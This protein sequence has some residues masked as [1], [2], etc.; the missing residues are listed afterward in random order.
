[1]KNILY[2]FALLLFSCKNNLEIEQAEVATV[3]LKYGKE[4]PD[5]EIIIN[6]NHGAIEVKLY[7]QTPLHRANFVRLIKSG[8]FADREI[9][10]IV[11]GLCIQGGG[12]NQDK[13][14]Y[15]IP[16]EFQPDIVHKKGAMAM[17]RY[18]N[19]NPDKMS[20]ATEFFIITKEAFYEPEELK[21]RSKEVQDIY[22][23][24][25]GEINFDNQYTVFGE[26]TKGIEVAEKIAKLEVYELEK[27]L[28]KPTFNIILK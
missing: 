17:A 1:M 10:R 26:V 21:G 14:K 19:N 11:K 28:N 18:E 24:Y 22:K 6:S 15:V 13:L 8:Y 25:G 3:L 2:L 7:E 4:N 12:E 20:S 5:N 16:A 27:P 9:Y 23:K